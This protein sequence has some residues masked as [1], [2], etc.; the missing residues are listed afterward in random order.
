MAW[1]GLDGR[2]QLL[3]T[4]MKRTALMLLLAMPGFCTAEMYGAEY[5]QCNKASTAGIVECVQHQAK[6]WDRRLNSAYKDLMARSDPAQQMPLKAAQRLWI[7]YRDA[8]CGFYAAGEGSIRQIES[9]ECLRAMT[10]QRT[11]ELRAANQQEGG[12]TPECKR[13]L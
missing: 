9:A 10:K 11:C 8:N 4:D 1:S 5:E 12:V 2:A 13:P 3:G 7:K 6:Q